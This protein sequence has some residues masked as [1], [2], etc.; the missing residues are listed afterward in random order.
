MIVAENAE[1]KSIARN[2]SHFKKISEKCSKTY[3]KNLLEDFD[4]IVEVNDEPE[5]E[6]SHSE[7][8]NNVND[9]KETDTNTKTVQNRV[10]TRSSNR[11]Q[12]E[13]NYF[14]DCVRF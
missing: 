8:S 1:G 13:P 14:K 10:G 7:V 11:K 5:V 4:D 12:R 2:S 3:K 9:A 6:D